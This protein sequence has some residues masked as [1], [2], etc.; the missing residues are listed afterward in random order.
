MLNSDGDRLR[1]GCGVNDV[2]LKSEVSSGLL[3]SPKAPVLPVVEKVFSRPVD[4]TKTGQ[5]KPGIVIY[6]VVLSETLPAQESDG[7]R[8]DK[9]GP[10]V[11]LTVKNETRIWK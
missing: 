1:R 10:S 3:E 8:V 7:G 5:R 2:G 6:E 4:G 11:V 9:G